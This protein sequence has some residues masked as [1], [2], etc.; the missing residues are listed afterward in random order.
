MVH[1]PNEGDDAKAAG[2]SEPVS[3]SHVQLYVDHVEDLLVY[4]DFEERLN[5]FSAA[6]KDCSSLV[7]KKRLWSGTSDTT[8]VPPFG[9]QNRDVVKQLLSSFGFRVTGARYGT[10]TRSVLV[11][12]R[13]PNGVQIL[14]TACA[15]RDHD[16]A[17]TEDDPTG[18]FAAGGW[19][20]NCL[21]FLFSFDVLL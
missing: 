17:T 13:D 16:A 21:I 9:P 14:V 4:K 12:S 3:F 8:A 18:I 7:V 1:Q 2:K 11:T 20:K 15:E 19:R 5:E 10:D 6:S